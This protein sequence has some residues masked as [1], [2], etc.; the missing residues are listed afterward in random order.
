MGPQVRAHLIAPEDGQ[1]LSHGLSVRQDEVQHSVSIEVCHHAPCNNADCTPATGRESHGEGGRPPV[2]HPQPWGGGGASAGRPGL[3]A[4]VLSFLAGGSGQE[5]TEGGS[6][7]LA[8]TWDT[9]RTNDS[10]REDFYYTRLLYL[11]TFCPSTT[12]L[13]VQCLLW[14]LT[15]PQSKEEEQDVEKKAQKMKELLQDHLRD[16]GR[17]GSWDS[18]SSALSLI[19]G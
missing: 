8:W 7:F 6:R 3:E 15:T 5:F 16:D 10:D 4:C 13:H 12:C 19:P 9:V 17:S 11:C 2:P 14:V 18:E 1:W